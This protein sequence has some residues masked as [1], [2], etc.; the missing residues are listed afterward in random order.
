ML[1]PN[2]GGPLREDA[3]L[4]P[5]TY[6]DGQSKEGNPRGKAQDQSIWISTRTTITEWVQ[7]SPTAPVGRSLT[8][9]Q[10]LP[11]T[12]TGVGFLGRPSILPRIEPGLGVPRTSVSAHGAHEKLT[13]STVQGWACDPTEPE[14]WAQEFCCGVWGRAPSRDKSLQLLGAW[15]A[16]VWAEPRGGRDQSLTT[17]P[18]T[19]I[20]PVPNTWIHPVSN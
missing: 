3:H 13:L 1:L 4:C 10:V 7:D 19:W 20:H 6:H 11:N 15:P 12:G 17:S 18:N 8:W 9:H 16:T 5:L 2:R 14:G